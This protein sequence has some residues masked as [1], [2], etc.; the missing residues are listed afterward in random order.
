MKHCKIFISIWTFE[1]NFKFSVFRTVDE[2]KCGD[3]KKYLN[4]TN[5]SSY[6]TRIT[7]YQK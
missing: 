3:S 5:H 4:Y 7:I 2:K 6:W 1:I